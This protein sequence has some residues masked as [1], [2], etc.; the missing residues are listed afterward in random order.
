M[1]MI[2]L[3][4]VHI[5]KSHKPEHKENGYMHRDNRA[6]NDAYLIGLLEECFGTPTQKKAFV[7]LE[8]KEEAEPV[9]G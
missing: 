5:F 2:L 3:L 9:W 8:P 7:K 6:E 1:C 4:E